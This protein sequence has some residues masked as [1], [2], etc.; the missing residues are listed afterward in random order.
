MNLP[1]HLLCSHH[2][3]F[4]IS[5]ILRKALQGGGLILKAALLC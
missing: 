3:A 1:E 5:Q 2:L 4:A